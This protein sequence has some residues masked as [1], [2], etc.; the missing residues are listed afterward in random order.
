MRASSDPKEM[1][2]RILNDDVKGILDELIECKPGDRWYNVKVVLG[3]KDIALTGEYAKAIYNDNKGI[4]ENALIQLRFTLGRNIFQDTDFKELK[5]YNKIHNLYDYLVSVDTN[6]ITDDKQDK[7][8]QSRFND[9]YEY[10]NTI[11]DTGFTFNIKRNDNKIIKLTAWDK[12]YFYHRNTINNRIYTCGSIITNREQK[13]NRC[14]FKP[15]FRD[16]NGNFVIASELLEI[17]LLKCLQMK[18][19]YMAGCL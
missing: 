8:I 14:I 6:R 16:D 1:L 15:L 2:D 7:D 13:G 9:L 12:V 4:L 3:L 5:G 17:H 11:P 10:Y 19:R 18:P